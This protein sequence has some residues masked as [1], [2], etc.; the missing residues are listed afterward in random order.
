MF[1]SLLL[2]FPGLLQ[3][4][5]GWSTC[6]RHPTA[7]ADSECCSQTG[8]HLPQFS[9]TAPLLCSLH[10]LPVDA[11]IRFKTL[12][13][14]YR[15][16]K[17]TAPSYIQ[18]LVKPYTPARALRSASANQLATPSLRVGPRNSSR[19]LLFVILAPKWWI[20]IDLRTAETLHILRRKLKTHLF[21][22][23]LGN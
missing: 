13:L 15:A 7:T 4:P 3:L 6:K 23:Y 9:L 19:T 2:G 22:L 14:A 1:V 20:P 12:V 5:P 16:V 8:L 21:Q 17:G 18:V 11:R 10:W